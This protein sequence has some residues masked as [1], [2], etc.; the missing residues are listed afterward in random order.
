M[1]EQTIQQ[2][3]QAVGQLHG[4]FKRLAT[5]MEADVA[6]IRQA[7]ESLAGASNAA[8]QRIRELQHEVVALKSEVA[9]LRLGNSRSPVRIVPDKAAKTAPAKPATVDGREVK[10]EILP[11][12][13]TESAEDDAFFAG[14]D[15]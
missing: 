7:L 11:P 6:M 8:Q 5:K 13:M 9:A 15:D 14:E 1:T 2:A 10:A 4:M 12:I 3:V